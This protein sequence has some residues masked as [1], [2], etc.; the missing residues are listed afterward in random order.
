MT[1]CESQYQEDSHRPMASEAGI[2]QP[3][4]FRP[5]RLSDLSHH[6]VRAPVLL[7]VGRVDV[8]RPEQRRGHLRPV[9]EAVV[10][11]HPQDRGPGGKGGHERRGRH[12]RRRGHGEPDQER[13]QRAVV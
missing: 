12:P 4:H 10:R 11:P 1:R 7:G 2:E 8:R 13:D 9:G 5:R 6:V 3:R